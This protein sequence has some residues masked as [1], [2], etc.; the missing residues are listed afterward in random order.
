MGKGQKNQS[1]GKIHNFQNF[2]NNH[3]SDQKAILT[4]V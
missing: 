2:L 3:F 1:L 4:K